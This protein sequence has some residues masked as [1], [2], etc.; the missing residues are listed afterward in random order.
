MKERRR[1]RSLGSARENRMSGL[2][3]ALSR[4]VSLGFLKAGSLTVESALALP[5]F[6]FGMTALI[7]L[8][9]L[10][11][12]ETVHLVELCQRTKAAATYTYNP[13]G[14]SFEDIV[15]PEA[16]SFQPVGGMLPVPAIYRVNVVRVRTWNGKEHET[17]HESLVRE[18]MVYVT[19]TGSVYHLALD[20]RYLKVQVTHVPAAQIQYRRNK[21]GAKYTAC[22]R[23]A[24]DG[25]AALVLITQSGNRYHND[26]NCSALKRTVRMIKLSE[27]A[28]YRPCSACG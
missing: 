22:E 4:R 25:P 11:R 1:R 26:E 18:K 8:M 10:Y 19:A 12:V 5:L 23:C 13:V 9:D 15:L 24:R 28:G 16:Y 20:C 27:A 6:F 3:R 17:R 2:L 14:G 7:S 21:S